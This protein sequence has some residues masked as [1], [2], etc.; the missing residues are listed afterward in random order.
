MMEF[1]YIT[2]GAVGTVVSLGSM[3]WSMTHIMDGKEHIAILKKGVKDWN[4]WRVRNRDIHP[5]LSLADFSGADLSG[6]NLIG[7]DLSEAKLRGGGPQRGGPL[8]GETIRNC[9]C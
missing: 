4:G 8:R 3:L 1:L 2:L 7:A 5:N 6:A 9:I